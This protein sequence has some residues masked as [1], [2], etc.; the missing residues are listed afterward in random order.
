LRDVTLAEDAL[1]IIIAPSVEAD[2]AAR[3]IAERLLDTP[4]QFAPADA[5]ELPPV[6]LLV[7]GITPQLEAF[8]LR[9][10]L[11]AVP[12]SLASRGTARVWTARRSSGSALLVV[13]ADDVEAL[14]ALLRPLPHYGGKSYLVFEGRRATETGTWPIRYSPLSHPFERSDSKRARQ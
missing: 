5:A 6:P 7:I 12:E 10:A 1:T 8:L 2:R 14:D 4:A 13:A 11:G 3:Q 9:A